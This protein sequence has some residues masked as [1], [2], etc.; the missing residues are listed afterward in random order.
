MGGGI[1]LAIVAGLW[2][3]LATGRYVSTDD[4]SVQAAQATISAN[5]PGRVIELDV[6]DNQAVRRGDVLFRL[7]D[8]QFP[9]R[10]RGSAGQTGR[11]AHADQRRQG[12]LPP[13]A[14]RSGRRARHAGL[15]A[16]RIRAPA[17]TAAVGHQLARAVR[18]GAA[19]GAA[20]AIA[21]QLG[22][23]AGRQRAGDARRQSGSAAR[24]ASGGDAG[25]GG[26]RS[27]QSRS[28]LY[29]DPRARRRRGGA[30]SSS[31]RSATTSMPRRRYSAWY[32][33]AMSGSRPISKKTT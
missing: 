6:H 23:A 22:A 30:R 16:A 28:V 4:S 20:G 13:P 2:Y 7:D 32:R 9:H 15:P 11:R 10:G 26:T 24:S 12:D 33:A 17:A 27:R 18:A 21:A 14:V 29:R 3:Y 25:A 19:R 8:R 31:C 1:V 5:L